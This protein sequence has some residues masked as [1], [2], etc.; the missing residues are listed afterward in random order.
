M[1]EN[2]AYLAGDPTA[3]GI[4]DIAGAR[5][6]V[7]VPMLKEDELIGAITIYRQEVRPFTE[8]QIALLSDF[9]SQAVIAIENTR[10]LKELRQRTRFARVF[11]SR[12]Q[13]PT[14]SR[15]SAA[16]PSICRQCCRRWWNRQRALRGRQG[17]DHPTKRMENLNWSRREFRL[18][19]RIHRLFSERALCARTRGSAFGRA[20]MEGAVVHIP[21]V[22]GGPRLY[23]CRGAAIG[24]LP[25]DPRRPHAT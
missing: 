6:V 25:H 22:A 19:Q 13:P 23:P 24:W 10:L 8:K 1:C 9:A 3:V 5:T 12:P 16:Q 7:I 14:C 17:D 4:V 11:N 18:F 15:S 21:D 20:L 2:P